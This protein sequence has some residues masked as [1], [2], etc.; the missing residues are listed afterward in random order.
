MDVTGAD[1]CASYDARDD[2]RDKQDQALVLL[3]KAAVVDT[4]PA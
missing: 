1:W 2:E 4:E 3:F